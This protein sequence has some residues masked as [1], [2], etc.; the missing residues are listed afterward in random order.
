MQKFN[1]QV[2]KK[3][4]TLTFKGEDQLSL[5]NVDIAMIDRALS[6]LVDNVISCTDA[7]G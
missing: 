3:I 1:L 6:N 2:E 4:L 7:G 5:V